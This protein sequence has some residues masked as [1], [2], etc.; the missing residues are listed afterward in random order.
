MNERV[1]IGAPSPKSTE[2]TK[3]MVDEILNEKPATLSKVNPKYSAE[4]LE[5]FL[6]NLY[7]KISRKDFAIAEYL[8]RRAI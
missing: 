2:N 7:G 5:D 8:V 4:E 3:K 1:S 6:D